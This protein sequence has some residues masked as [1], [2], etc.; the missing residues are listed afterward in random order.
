[1]GLTAIR[2]GIE[3]R[4]ELAIAAIVA[5]AVL[6]TL[7]GIIARILKSTSRFG[8]ELDSLADFVNFGVAPA[9]LLYNW[10]LADTKSAGW[11]AVLVFSLCCALRL[12]RF[13]ASLNQPKPA[14]T[15]NFFVGMPAPAGAISL[16]LPFY[17]EYLGVVEMRSLAPVIMIYTGIIALLMVSQIP[18]FSVK[19]MG[20][21]VPR[22]FVMP[23]PPAPVDGRRAEC[24]P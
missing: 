13:N 2:M 19:A 9:V 7:D 6:D 24:P 5:A 23:S 20:Q 10:A 22:E 16:L 8:A 12:A 21:R 1:M 4:F 14:W 3:G 17:I 18:T 15:V 11:I